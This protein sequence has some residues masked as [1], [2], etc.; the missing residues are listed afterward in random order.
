[1]QASGVLPTNRHYNVVIN[2]LAKCKY[3]DAQKAQNLLRDLQ[4]LETY[5]PDII[6]YT[7]VIECFSKSSNQDA[8]GI[9]LELFEEAI[10]LYQATGDEEIMPNLRSY[11]V[12]IRAVST[13]PTP[14]N[15]QI[16]R[17]LLERLQKSYE[18]TMDKSLRPNTYPFNYVINCA[19]NCIGST[20]DKCEAFKIAAKTYNEVRKSKF[21]E[22]DSFTYAFWFKCCNNLLPQGET[23]TKGVTL[24][25]Q[26]C[27]RSGLVAPE[28][29]K[30]F[31]AGTPQKLVTSLLDIPDNTHPA[32][33]RKYTLED[34]PP[35]WS[36][37]VRRAE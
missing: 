1:M 24:A 5:S 15:V 26:Q 29:L 14:E 2:A 20:D 35:G 18:D 31:L 19:A 9:C 27:T 12:A 28:T 36:R 16:S 7:S 32:V 6:T 33:Y 8:A 17:D 3:P 13:N 34:I 10:D 11:T 25:F 23:R 22:P 21:V 4:A 37:N 30:R